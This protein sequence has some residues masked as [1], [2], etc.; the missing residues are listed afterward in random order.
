MRPVSAAESTL[1]P[2]WSALPEEALLRMRVC[3]LG[4][5]L[6]SSGL[7]RHV[8]QLSAELE[9]RGLVFRPECYLGDEWFSPEDVPSISLPFWL[10]HPRLAALEK[11]MMLE[12]EGGDPVWCQ[13]LLRHEC[14]HAIEHAY[15]LHRRA[16]RQQLF[17]KRS[18]DYDPDTY[19]PQPY[20]RSFVRHLPNWYAQAHPDEDFAETFAVWLDPAS[21]WRRHYRGW[22]A[23]AKLE[24]MDALMREIG[25]SPPRVTGGPN[26]DEVSTLKVTLES[27]YRR[28]RKL[29]ETDLPDFYDNDLKRI[30]TAGE[31]AGRAKAAAFLRRQKRR[32]VDATARWTGARKVTI[33][34]LV[35]R[36]IE[37]A[38]QLDL[39]MNK[40]EATTALEF[41][42]WLAVVVTNW[43][44]TGKFKRTV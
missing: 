5:T 7:E 25:R 44:F 11:K 16:K 40:D 20:S 28:R 2:A 9:G 29:Y 8:A 27:L 18:A 26:E 4:L 21:D 22:K 6:E 39:P 43:R 24:Y 19:R 38:A 33:E 37:R 30:F 41:S 1:Q 23:L 42:S 15:R 14:G 10:A 31:P 34:L 3:D 32:V 35:K 13:R 17:G 36:L 12:V